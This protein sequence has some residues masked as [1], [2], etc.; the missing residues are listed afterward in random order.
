MKLST[1]FKTL[2]YEIALANIADTKVDFPNN[3]LL[4]FLAANDA[5]KYAKILAY[6]NGL[7]NATFTPDEKQKLAILV[8]KALP[9]KA[10]FAQSFSLSLET[11]IESGKAIIFNVPKYLVKAI[12][13]VTRKP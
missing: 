11:D 8:W 9:S 4:Q 1:A 5:T 2:E 13:Y 6:M 7:A 12:K 10:V 3:Y